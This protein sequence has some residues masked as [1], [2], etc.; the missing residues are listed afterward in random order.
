MDLEVNTHNTTN[1]MQEG[2]II[3]KDTLDFNR[4]IQFF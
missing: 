2:F 3:N 4:D 1:Y